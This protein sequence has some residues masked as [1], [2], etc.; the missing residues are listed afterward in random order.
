MVLFEHMDISPVFELFGETSLHALQEGMHLESIADRSKLY[1]WEISAHR[2]EKLLQVLYMQSGGGDMLMQGEYRPLT[3]PSVTIVAPGSTHGFS[4]QRNVCGT[5]LSLTQ[6]KLSELLLFDRSL[7]ATFSRSHHMLLHEAPLENNYLSTQLQLLQM[8]FQHASAWRAAQLNACGTSLLICLARLIRKGMPHQ[9]LAN[10]A[11]SHVRAF[12]SLIDQHF[13]HHHSLNFYARTLGITGAQL[14]RVCK[15]TTQRSAGA[16]IQDRRM[17]EACRDLAFSV[18]SI[19]QIAFALGFQ[20]ESYFTRVF[21]LRMQRTPLE[22][23][24]AMQATMR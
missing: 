5:V 6:Q 21:R 19:K 17:T 15:Q 22:Y 7:Q 16:L 4:F 3:A 20:D 8:E 24:R 9:A 14:T 10:R 11:Q 12:Q 1:D 2:H 18:L 13:R 23:R